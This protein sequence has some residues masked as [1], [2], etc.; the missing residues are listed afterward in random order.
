MTTPRQHKPASKAQP[1]IIGF[2][3]R[4]LKW[5]VLI[6]L[7]VTTVL[8]AAE[9]LV[10]TKDNAAIFYRKY[11]RLTPRPRYVGANINIPCAAPPTQE[12]IDR[13]RAKTG[14]HT[15]VFLHIYANPSAAAAIAAK[16]EQ[17]P[18]GAVIVKEKLGPD[19][20]SVAGIG[21]MIKR[22]EGYDA[23]NGDWEFF[24]YTPGG[25]FTTGKVANCVDCHKNG[26]RDHVFNVWTLS[27][28]NKPH[29]SL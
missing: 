14:P 11:Q 9:P 28:G 4:R 21:G 13:Q 6:L 8:W 15:G 10:V 1:S 26:K 5:P 16:E 20:K 7:S 2:H 19:E 24:F 3:P 12:D 25:D 23:A 18:V 29:A 27:T 22:A 17:F